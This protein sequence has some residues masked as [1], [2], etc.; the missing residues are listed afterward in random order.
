MT[1]T[2]RLFGLQ[3]QISKRSQITAIMNLKGV[4][5]RLSLNDS[6]MIDI[7]NI[8]IKEIK[9]KQLHEADLI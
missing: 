4:G 9:V 2:Q 7:R 6:K 8:K 3:V 1:P 5:R